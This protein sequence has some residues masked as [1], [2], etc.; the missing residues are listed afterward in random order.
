MTSYIKIPSHLTPSDPQG[1]ELLARERSKATF[2][3]NELTLVLYGAEGLSRFKKI[4]KILESDPTLDKSDIYYMGRNELFKYALRKD[5]RMIQLAATHKWSAD[6]FN[7]ADKLVDM[8]GPYGIHQRMFIPT[9][10]GQGTDEQKSKFLT[11]ALKHEIIGCYA[12]TELGHGSNVQGLETTATYIPETDEFEIHTPHLTAAKWWAGGLGRTANHSVVMARLITNG[13]D[14]GPHPFIVQIRDLTTHEPLPGIT[15]GDI[16]PKFGYNSTDNGFML[17]DHVRIPRFNMLSKYSQVTKGTGE[18]KNP[19]NEKLSY[20]TMV[21]VRSIIILGAGLALARAATISV[22]YSA[23]RRQFVDKENPTILPN[24]QVVETAVLDYTMQQ[25]RLFPVIAQAYAIYFTGEIIINLY[26][27]YIDQSSRGEFS[28]LAD[29]H[30]S[31]SGLKSLTT[32][33]AVDSIEDCRR[34]CGGHGYSNFSG[35]TRFYQ[36]YLPNT[37]WEGDN[38]ILTQQTARYLFKTYREILHSKQQS[39]EFSLR[40]NESPTIAYMLRY[41]SNPS[42]KCTVISPSDF[43]NPEVQ[44]AIYGYRAAYLIARAVDQIDN[45]KKSWNSMLV[46][47]NRISRAHCEYI[48]VHNFILTLQPQTSDSMNEKRRILHN[49]PSLK[50]GLTSVCNLFALHTM[51]KNLSE[52]LESGYLSP[53][54]SEML[55]V[56]ISESLNEIRP[57]AVALVDAFYLPDYLLN[58]A[59]GRYD[60]KVYE[61]MIEWASKEPLNGITLDVNPYSDKLF[62]N[63]VKAKI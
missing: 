27:Q 32:S 26:K 60:G 38:Y 40:S 49:S 57:N 34:A 25:Y 50:T 51:E 44:L 30:A 48:L 29:L 56:Q 16:G 21:F 33:I 8:S 45:H 37:T 58:S 61:T 63:D 35:F 9:I 5:K 54:Q 43:K 62:R 7:V 31:T 6:E 28:L 39:E 15:I 4:L 59:L 41:L 13:Q 10:M 22:R 18:Y 1:S 42:Q 23:V 47:I 46:E 11:P 14:K 20:G 12:Q 24:G 36:D 3:V 17:F 2:D 52:S 55:R 19:P 53:K